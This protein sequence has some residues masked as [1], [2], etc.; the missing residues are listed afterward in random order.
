[1]EVFLAGEHMTIQHFSEDESSS[2]MTA[3]LS[4]CSIPSAKDCPS[5]DAIVSKHDN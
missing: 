5:V 4:P 2:H 3:K 1:M